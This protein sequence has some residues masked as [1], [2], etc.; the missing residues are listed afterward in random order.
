MLRSQGVNPQQVLKKL[1]ID[2]ELFAGPDRVIPMQDLGRLLRYGVDQSGCCHIGLLQCCNVGL[3]S[4]SM[5]EQL[6]L[7]GGTLGGALVR[8]VDHLWLQNRGDLLI[9]SEQGDSLLLG[10]MVNTPGVQAT[11]QFEDGAI[12]IA[13]NIL[14]QFLGS[15]WSPQAVTFA[16]GPPRENKPYQDF[17]RCDLR[18]NAEI[19]G[20]LF[21]RSLL[22]VP[23]RPKASNALTRVERSSSLPLTDAVRRMIPKMLLDR[24]CTQDVAARRLGMQK[25]TLI[26]RLRGEGASFRDL[27]EEIRYLR[28]QQ[29]LLNTQLSITEI[30]AILNYSELSAFTRAFRR[31]SGRAPGDWRN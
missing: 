12:A 11:S 17:F 19:T 8:L 9:L 18:F 28:A 3:S 13:L 29:L 20:L 5:I 1:G 21:S 4:M 2:Q 14:R 6:V 24:N 23:L 16:H 15:G 31:W 30:A 10:F 25:R 7:S 27:V 22:S 26:R